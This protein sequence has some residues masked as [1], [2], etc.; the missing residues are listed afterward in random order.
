MR[1]LRRLGAAVALKIVT[2]LPA[3]TVG[4]AR[5]SGRLAPLLERIFGALGRPLTGRVVA[6]ADG[7][8]KGLRV[9]GERRSLAW[10]S[11]GVESEIQF[12]LERELALGGV[13]VDAGASIGFFALL[14]ARIVGTDRARHRLRAT[15]S[16][17][18]LYPAQRRAELVRPC[19]G[20]RGRP[21]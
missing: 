2:S 10:L 12:V 8:G 18:G 1:P 20:R 16:G 14:A 21:E 17:G 3:G 13:F 9:V 11:G 15:A 7:P 6:I 19:H 4:R 5:V